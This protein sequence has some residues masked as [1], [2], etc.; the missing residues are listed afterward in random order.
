VTQSLAIYLIVGAVLFL[1]GAVANGVNRER[2]GWP[3]VLLAV[4][5]AIIGWPIFWGYAIWSAEW[6]RRS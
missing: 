3:E 5:A 6:E 4:I 1:I 2:P